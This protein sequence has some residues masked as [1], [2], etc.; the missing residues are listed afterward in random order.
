MKPS[1][2]FRATCCPLRAA[3]LSAKVR[4]FFVNSSTAPEINHQSQQA[5]CASSQLGARTHNLHLHFFDLI[6]TLNIVQV[7]IL[8]KSKQINIVNASRMSVQIWSRGGHSSVWR[9]QGWEASGLFGIKKRV[10]TKCWKFCLW[11]D[12]CQDTFKALQRDPWA[13][14]QTSKF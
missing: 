9:G 13:K 12:R 3:C 2:A 5:L 14:Y 11:Q 7:W 6:F 10:W 4:L 8:F 1:D